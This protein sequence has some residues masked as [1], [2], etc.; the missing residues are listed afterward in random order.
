MSA[1]NPA[2]LYGFGLKLESG[3]ISSSRTAILRW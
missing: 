2:S 1:T 3:G